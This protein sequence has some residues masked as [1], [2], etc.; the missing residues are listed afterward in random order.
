MEKIEFELIPKIT[1]ASLDAIKAAI[2]PVLSGGIGGGALGAI[3]SLI[4]GMG[5]VGAAVSAVG[6]AVG[7]IH[8]AA[9]TANPAYVMQFDMAM[10]DVT[11]VIGQS[12]A[13]VI[14]ALTP[15]VRLFGDF[16]ANILPTAEE[17][18]DALK[19]MGDALKMVKSAIDPLIPIFRERFQTSI[20]LV[21]KALQTMLPW[22][23]KVVKAYSLAVGTLSIVQNA[24]LES[25]KNFKI[26]DPTKS[27]KEAFEKIPGKV[28]DLWKSLYEGGKPTNFKK[29]SVGAA[30]HGEASYAGVADIGREAILSAFSVGAGQTP[31]KQT[32]ENTKQMSEDLKFIMEEVKKQPWAKQIPGFKWFM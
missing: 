13:P 32:A 18:D 8:G 7:Q 6:G 17:M 29:S 16:L 27:F 30:F 23:E 20:E 5:P 3:S 14:K 21:S 19:P 26:T 11:G 31:E 9:A 12:L 2:S 1:S 10:K 25:F 15:W 24:M 28:K 4:P 22:I